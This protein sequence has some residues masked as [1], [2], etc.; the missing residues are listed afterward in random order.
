ML[1]STSR[2]AAAIH[3]VAWMNAIRLGAVSRVRAPA[4]VVGVG[5]EGQPEVPPHD[6]DGDSDC[7]VDRGGNGIEY[8]HVTLAQVG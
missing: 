2:S 3:T 5:S 4:P 7:C 1:M 8:Q 6:G